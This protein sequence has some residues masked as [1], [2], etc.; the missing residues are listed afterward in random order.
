MDI[1]SANIFR[2]LDNAACTYKIGDLGHV[3]PH[4]ERVFDDG[5]CRYAAREVIQDMQIKTENN[6]NDLR[7]SDIFSLGEIPVYLCLYGYNL[8]EFRYDHGGG[9]DTD[10]ASK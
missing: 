10:E 8:S 5:D 7:Q 3:C 9:L 2:H 6:E 1:K 4:N